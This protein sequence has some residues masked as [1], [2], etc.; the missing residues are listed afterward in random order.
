MGL[1]LNRISLSY[2]VHYCIWFCSYLFAKPICKR[3]ADEKLAPVLNTHSHSLSLSL[4]AYIN[5]MPNKN[6]LEPCLLLHVFFHFLRC[7][8][9]MCWKCSCLCVRWLLVNYLAH[10]YNHKWPKSAKECGQATSILRS[11]DWMRA[12]YAI[13]CIFEFAYKK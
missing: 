4:Y 1:C 3:D 11:I 13:N 12:S 10:I 7:M 5:Y 2:R 8:R 9:I 6:Q